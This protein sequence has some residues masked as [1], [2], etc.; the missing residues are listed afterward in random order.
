MMAVRSL[1]SPVRE[2]T[3]TSLRMPLMT[4]AAALLLAGCSLVPDY[5]RPAAPV[6]AALPQNGATLAGVGPTAADAPV[7]ADIPWQQFFTDPTLQGLI[8]QALETNRSLR[9]AA[10]NVEVARATYRVREADTLPEVNATAGESVQRTPRNASTATPARDMISRKY[11]ASLAVTS[12]ELDLFGRVRSLESA[13]LE[14]YLATEEARTAAQISLIAEVAN[15]YLTL[16]GDRKLLALTEETLQ[17]RQQSLQLIERSFQLGVGSQL[18]VSQARSSVETARASRLR[19]LRQVEQD[20]NAL[21]LLVGQPVDVAVPGDLRTVK[22]VED[23]PVGLSSDVLL[24][25]PDIAQAEHTL[26]SANANIGAAR[27]AF[28]PTI[29]LTGS[30]GLSSNTLQ[31]LF[32]A[33]SGAWAFAP[34][35]SL[36]IFDA[37][38][39]EAELDSAKATKDIAVANYEKAIQ[40]AFREVADSLAARGTY[41]E[42]LQAQN[43]LVDAYSNSLQLSQARYDRG[44]DSYLSVLDA[45]RS[46]FSAQQEQVTTE[47]ARLSTLVTLYK[48][49]GGGVK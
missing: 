10:L 26:K 11:S 47:V 6:P 37:G 5:D 7:W 38:K 21:S 4:A 14:S 3:M 9:V 31:N 41:G 20:R 35:L 36:P 42:Q 33:G 30:F 39:N 34:S 17:S 23:I 18:D 16:L 15:A 29:S 12:F 13:A 40:T 27:A 32:K 19:Y 25:R 8:R 2:T 46:L 44:I 24:R 1:Q 28:F 48:T 43:A 49:L 45:Q 22:L